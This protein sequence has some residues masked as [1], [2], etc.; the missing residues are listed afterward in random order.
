[1]NPQNPVQSSGTYN[2]R[3]SPRTLA[4]LRAGSESLSR[5]S[6]IL[7]GVD[8]QRSVSKSWVVQGLDVQYEPTKNQ[9]ANEPEG[10]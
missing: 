9:F 8:A 1:M 6:Q 2:R 4:T 5:L 3:P 7:Y 10:L